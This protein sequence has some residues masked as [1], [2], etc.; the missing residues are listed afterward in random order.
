MQSN[1][2][3]ELAVFKAFWEFLLAVQFF[4]LRLAVL[5]SELLDGFSLVHTSIY[6]ARKQTHNKYK[7]NKGFTVE[8]ESEEI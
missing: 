5:L 4:R 6:G 7:E 2:E 8:L 1:D 3:I